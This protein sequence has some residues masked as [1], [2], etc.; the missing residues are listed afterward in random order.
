MEPI[1]G[2]K[3]GAPEG[4]IKDSDA[5]GFAADVI[6]ASRQ[7]PVLV[8][9]WAPWC[10]PCKQLTPALEKVVKA[11]GGAVRL[12]KINID[13]NQQ[14]A[15]QFRVQSI[16]AVFA[17]K[18]GQPVDGFVGVQPESSIR[19]LVERLGGAA[20]GPSPVEEA[21]AQA[22]A[23]AETGD[24]AGAAR[25]Y[26]QVLQHEAGN[27]MAL[28]GLARCHLANGDLERA[29]QTLEMAPPEHQEH[30]EISAAKAALELARESGG[31]GE[32]WPLRD[33]LARN[34]DDKQARY[35][36]ALGLYRAGEAEGAIDEL[37]ELVRRDR[38]WNDEAARKQL[39]KVFDALGPGDP[40]TLTA[41]RR[42]SSLLF[43]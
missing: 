24:R 34:P 19:A 27:A 29:R 2:Q 3:A 40:L 30:A 16:P 1:I 10:G 6:E 20:A 42:L 22:K 5:Q 41:R 21:L 43:S 25:L 18:G 7:T 8:D 26:G 11:A 13:E 23:A 12:V 39:L 4:L 36:L 37:L 33:A 14:L 15:Q 35:D 38:D 17:F 9:F 28:A 32:V 31:A